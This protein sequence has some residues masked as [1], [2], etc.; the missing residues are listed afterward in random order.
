MSNVKSLT[1][2]SPRSVA[3]VVN[4][5]R[6]ENDRGIVNN[7]VNDIN[8]ALKNTVRNVDNNAVISSKVND[9]QFDY[10]MSEKSMRSKLLKGAKRTPFEVDEKKICTVLNFSDGAYRLVVLPLLNELQKC[11]CDATQVS[12]AWTRAVPTGGTP[13]YLSLVLN[14]L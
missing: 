5:T 7:T 6:V 4:N 12:I 1:Y 2:A 9:R 11:Y 14:Y 13:T 8:D 3:K 10:V